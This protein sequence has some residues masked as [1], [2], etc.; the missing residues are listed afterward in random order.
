VSLSCAND[1]GEKLIPNKNTV[2]TNGVAKVCCMDI[3]TIHNKLLRLATPLPYL[4]SV[5]CAMIPVC[6][7]A[8]L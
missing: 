6:S 8:S 5:R 1:A 4:F 7:S 2:D 3:P